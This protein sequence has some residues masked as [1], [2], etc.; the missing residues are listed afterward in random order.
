MG[1]DVVG[2]WEGEKVVTRANAIAQLRE[3]ILLSAQKCPENYNAALYG[4]DYV[5]P[6][7]LH[8]ALYTERSINDCEVAILVMPCGQNPDQNSLFVTNLYRLTLRLCNPRPA[9]S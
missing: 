6:G 8:A 2:E 7:E 5:V 4:E 9:G 1:R 3:A